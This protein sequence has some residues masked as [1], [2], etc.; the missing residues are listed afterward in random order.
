MQTTTFYILIF[1]KWMSYKFKQIAFRLFIHSF[2]LSEVQPVHT[3][4]KKRIEFTDRFMKM[5][6]VFATLEMLIFF[7][8]ALFIMPIG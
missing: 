4:M 1:E 3:G 6:L 8:L 2:C 7:L 5:K